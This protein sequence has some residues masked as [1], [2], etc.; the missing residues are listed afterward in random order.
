MSTTRV[1][2]DDQQGRK[3][4]PRKAVLLEVENKQPAGALSKFRHSLYK[5]VSEVDNLQIL[6]E[7][8]H[9]FEVI[10]PCFQHYQVRR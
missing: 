3:L 5:V 7:E 2:E 6:R 8:S 10:V 4:V 1:L 9:L